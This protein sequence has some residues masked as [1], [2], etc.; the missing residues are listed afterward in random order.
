[1]AII[2]DIEQRSEE[3][4]SARAG[5]VGGSSIDK[6]ITP[7]G[8]PSKSAEGLLYQLAGERIVGKCEEGFT[9]QAM[10][11][12]IERESQARQL[13]E[14]AYGVD[15]QQVGIVYKDERKLFHCSPDGLVGDDAVLEIKCPMLKTH[16]QYLLKAEMP[17]DYIPQVQME[18]Y[19]T[20]RTKCYFM[21]YYAGMPPLIVEVPRDNDYIN[22]L[23]KLLMNFIQKL[24]QATQKIRDTSREKK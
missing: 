13:F 24:S 2:I 3:W 11:N 20:E 5:S 12:G 22:L 8:Q 14:L 17:K 4:M 19:V 10:L 18:M 21:S 1:M 9:S 23:E 7:T 15:V 6:I 16:V